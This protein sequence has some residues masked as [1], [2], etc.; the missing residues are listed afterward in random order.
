MTNSVTIFKSTFQRADFLNY[1]KEEYTLE[2]TKYIHVLCTRK[3]KI[4]NKAI[5]TVQTTQKLKGNLLL[6]LSSPFKI[7][8]LTLTCNWY[9]KS[10][11]GGKVTKNHAGQPDVVAVAPAIGCWDDR[12]TQRLEVNHLFHFS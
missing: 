9:S 6:R 12:H 4:G 10:R 7:W 2:S 8:S 11:S 5:K 3:Y 1:S